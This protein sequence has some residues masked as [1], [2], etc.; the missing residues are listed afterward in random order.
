MRKTGPMFISVLGRSELQPGTWDPSHYR[1]NG[2]RHTLGEYVSAQRLQTRGSE[3]CASFR[4]IEYK[5]IPRGSALTFQLEPAPS[6]VGRV[7]PAVGEQA[8]LLGTMRAYLGNIVVTPRGEWLSIPSPT[9]FAVNAE[10]LQ[11]VPKDD[12]IY[13]WWAYL[14]SPEFLHNLPIGTGGTRPRLGTEAL[15][16]TPVS[17]SS[18]AVRRQVHQKLLAFAAREWKELTAVEVLLRSTW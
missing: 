7:G 4:A 8:L 2:N 6:G 9:Y 3:S 1:Q 12:C 16:R 15:L 17:A 14:K 5:H 11:V 10:F 13:F 18:I